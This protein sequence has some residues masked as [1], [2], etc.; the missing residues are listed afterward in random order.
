MN[1]IEY[2]TGLFIVHMVLCSDLQV[3]CGADRHVEIESQRRAAAGATGP[4]A[5]QGTIRDLKS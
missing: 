2:N 5:P 3:A 1:I 4:L